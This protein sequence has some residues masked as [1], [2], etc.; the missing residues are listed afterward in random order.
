MPIYRY[1][2]GEHGGGFIGLRVAV[3][4]NKELI[5]PELHRELFIKQSKQEWA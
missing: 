5:N 3:L 2:E 1:K 4:V